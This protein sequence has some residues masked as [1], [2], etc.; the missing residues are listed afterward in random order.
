MNLEKSRI[1]V[2]LSQRPFRGVYGDLVST[3]ESTR[4]ASVIRVLMGYDETIKVTTIDFD[5][6]KSLLD[7]TAGEAGIYH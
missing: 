6:R 3:R 7:F 1:Q 5:H 4:T 2:H